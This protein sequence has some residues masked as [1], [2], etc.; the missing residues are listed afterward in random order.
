MAKVVGLLWDLTVPAARCQS[1]QQARATGTSLSLRAPSCHI[2]W[3]IAL[4]YGPPTLWSHSVC[5]PQMIPDRQQYRGAHLAQHQHTRH[6]YN[7]PF[8]PMWVLACT[9]LLPV[10]M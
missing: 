4:S 8:H 6:S 9:I 1:H 2:Y 5:C 10:Q 3:V 7:F